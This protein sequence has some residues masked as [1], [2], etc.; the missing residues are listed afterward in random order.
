[1]A[2][3]TKKKLSGS[4]NGRGIKVVTTATTGTTIHTAVAGTTD[5]DEVWLFAYNG[6]TAN[7][8]LTIEF[9]GVS[10]PD[11]NIKVT[12]VWQAG[13]QLIV[14]GLILQNECVVRAFASVANVVVIT[15]FVNNIAAA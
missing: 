11:D 12:L 13:L 14:P 4:T 8:V 15:G 3:F 1:M 2:T 9:G 7:V 5:F 10:V 6:H